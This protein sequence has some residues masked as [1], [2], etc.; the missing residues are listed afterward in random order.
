MQPG[1]ANFTIYAGTTF[2]QELQWLGPDQVTP[3]DITGL[4]WRMQIKADS[5][6]DCATA[7]FATLDSNDGSITVTPLLGQLTLNI[8]ETTTAG[9]NFTTGVYDLLYEDTSN[10]PIVLPLLTGTVT[11]VPTV[12][13]FT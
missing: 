11:V 3:I 1:I 13:R 4:R 12:T 6:P 5:S 8:P 2:R 9:F 10:P 7:S